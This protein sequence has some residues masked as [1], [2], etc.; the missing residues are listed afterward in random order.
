[1]LASQRGIFPYENGSRFLIIKFEFVSSS[2][3]A[4]ISAAS[5][6]NFGE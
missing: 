1:M 2:T 3:R 4:A 6:N 5:L